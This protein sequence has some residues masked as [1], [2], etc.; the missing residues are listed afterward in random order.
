MG[1]NPGTLDLFV[2]WSK[3][4]GIRPGAAVLDI[5]TSE[6][7]CADDPDS[8]NRFLGHFGGALYVDGD[9]ERMANRAFAA[10]LFQRAGL[11]YRAV[12]IRRFPHTLSIDLNAGRLPFWHRGRYDVVMNS[13]TTEHVLNQLNAFRLIHD[14]CK[15][16]GLMYHGV[17][18]AGDFDHGFIS[19]NP[20]FFTR[21]QESNGYEILRR[22]IWASQER[23]DYEELELAVANRPFASHN[24]FVHFLLRRRD[25]SPFRVPLDCTDYPAPKSG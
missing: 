3:T 25:A 15:V 17:P 6:L 2:E 23:R 21:L 19:Y 7:F 18:L 22:W 12:D 1:I 9:L 4:Y 24:V 10:E 8:L 5:G 16:G 11:A 20:K 13:G 14:S